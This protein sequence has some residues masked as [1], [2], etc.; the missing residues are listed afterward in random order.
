MIVLEGLAKE[1]ERHG[2][3]GITVAKCDFVLPGTCYVMNG[4]VNVSSV[5]YEAVVRALYSK[6]TQSEL[7]ALH[8]LQKPVKSIRH[9]RLED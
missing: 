4:V 5:D 1:L 8:A 9:I 6:Q 2:W 7:P 3:A